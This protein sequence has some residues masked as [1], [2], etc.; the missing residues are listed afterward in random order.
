MAESRAGEAGRLDPAAMHEMSGLDY[1]RTVFAA[2]AGAAIGETVGFAAARF[3]P[4]EAEFA[5]TPGARHCNPLGT[6]HGGLAA[7]LLD[8]AMGC[9]VHTRLEPGIGY[10]TAELKINY[11]RAMTPQ[12]GEVRA[13][14]KVVHVGRQL[15]VA[16]GRLTG[17]DGRLYAT[18]STTC[19]VFPLPPAVARE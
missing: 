9:A 3:D 5:C 19:L 14:G 2:G 17:A 4:G 12:T 11:I 15:A 1:L 10:T 16:E 6:V 8:S 13:V 18:G 7:T